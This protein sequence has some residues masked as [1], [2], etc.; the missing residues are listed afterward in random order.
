MMLSQRLL[1]GDQ[2]VPKLE[3]EQVLP[4]TRKRYGGTAPTS[5]DKVAWKLNG[6]TGRI[7][8]HRSPL[9]PNKWLTRAELEKVQNSMVALETVFERRRG[10]KPVTVLFEGQEGWKA[11]PGHR[12]TRNYHRYISGKWVYSPRWGDDGY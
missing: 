12:H 11:V 10:F 3:T 2:P 1:R 8:V 7:E 6:S 9:D 4:I 5:K